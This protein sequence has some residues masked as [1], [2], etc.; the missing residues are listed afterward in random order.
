MAQTTYR[1]AQAAIV[2]ALRSDGWTVSLRD[3]R[4]FKELKIPYVT[5][6]DGDHRLWFKAQAIYHGSPRT[7]FGEARSMW[8]GDIRNVPTKAVVNEINRQVVAARW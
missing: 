2:E 7:G 6:A 1:Q 4:T 8:L 5:S 3:S